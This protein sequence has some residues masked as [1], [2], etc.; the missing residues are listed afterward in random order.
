MSSPLFAPG[1]RMGLVA[2]RLL[3]TDLHSVYLLGRISQ[4]DSDLP[5][6]SHTSRASRAAKIRAAELRTL[7]AVLHER[8]WGNLVAAGYDPATCTPPVPVIDSCG[9]EGFQ[10]ALEWRKS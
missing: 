3:I 7:T 5:S 9:D 6:F 4:L 1:P 10:A 8:V 2:M